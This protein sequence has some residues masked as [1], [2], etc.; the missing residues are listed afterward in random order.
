MSLDKKGNFSQTHLN[1]S[2]VNVLITFFNTHLITFNLGRPTEGGY[3]T[4]LFAC[5]LD[6]CDL[7]IARRFRSV[8]AYELPPMHVDTRSEQS[9]R[10]LWTLS[11][12]SSASVQ[13][14][15]T[16]KNKSLTTTSGK[17]CLSTFVFSGCG[18]SGVSFCKTQNLTGKK[19]HYNS[20]A[21]KLNSQSQKG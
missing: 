19:M 14:K 17:L 1:P 10:D 3:V 18:F 4:C 12:H 15:Q 5:K 9:Y 21:Y 11:D 16:N 2:S 20:R 13:N 8:N 7:R 6:N